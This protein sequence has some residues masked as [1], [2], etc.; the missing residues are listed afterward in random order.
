MSILAQK[1]RCYEG[2]FAEPLSVLTRTISTRFAGGTCRGK[3]AY[4]MDFKGGTNTT[5]ATTTTTTTTF[6]KLL[7]LCITLMQDIV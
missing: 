1:V 2:E 5:T 7:L 4:I 3:D 6:L